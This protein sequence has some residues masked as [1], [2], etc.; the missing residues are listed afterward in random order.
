VRPEGSE[1]VVP[2]DPA[3]VSAPTDNAG[4]P[5]HAPPSGTDSGEPA[6]DGS[7]RASRRAYG[8]LSTRVSW[9]R[10]KRA[11]VARSGRSQ[12]AAGVILGMLGFMTVLQLQVQATDDNYLTA[13][14]P[15]LIE[16]LD[17][18]GQRSSRLQDEVAQLEAEKRELQSGAD[19]SRAAT[20][21][22]EKR[23][24]SLG[25]LAGTVKA[26]GPGIRLY[27]ENV[28][29]AVISALLLN[30]VQELRDAGAEALEINDKVRITAST[31]FV[32]G[33][34]KGGVLVAGVR[35]TGPFTID[36]IGDPSTLETA[37]R[38]PGGVEDEV[39]QQGGLVSVSHQ[40]QVDVSSLAS[41]DAPAN[42]KP[43]G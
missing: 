41:G 18:L 29:G 15:Q 27:I 19:S 14:R 12:V 35:V 16:I 40:D 38:I 34:A 11:T 37:M 22:A 32:D 9:A 33:G 1:P 23:A 26:T 7:V 17:G 42:A 8:A 25:I 2:T 24:E 39:T 3:E 30:T 31:P 13:T 4:P 5:G 43:D 36:V 20:E 28:D 21:Q 10:L 6:A